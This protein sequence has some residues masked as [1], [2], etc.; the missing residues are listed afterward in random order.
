MRSIPEVEIDLI[1]ISAEIGRIHECNGRF[2]YGLSRILW[3][4]GKPLEDLTVKELIAVTKQYSE[5]F[6]RIDRIAVGQPEPEAPVRENEEAEK[7]D[8]LKWK[9]C[10]YG[11]VQFQKCEHFMEHLRK[12][13][14]A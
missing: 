5:V 7:L 6:N 4:R 8:R 1:D 12:L 11:D 9:E 10:T 14:S 3:E 13:K 2:T